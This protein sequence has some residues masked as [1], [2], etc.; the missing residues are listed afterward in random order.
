M[1]APAVAHEKLFLGRRCELTSTDWNTD[2]NR[3]LPRSFNGGI[4]RRLWKVFVHSEVLHLKVCGK[5]DNSP[6]SFKPLFFVLHGSA[7]GWWTS[8][9]GKVLAHGLR[10]DDQAPPRIHVYGF[11]LREAGG[12]AYL[13]PKCMFLPTI[14]CVL[15][16]KRV[17]LIYKSW[18]SPAR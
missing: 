12:Y 11:E 5:G 16:I 2:T 3:D 1:S 17:A 18:R 7:D 4:E 9:A 6:E 15:L 8:V 13:P 14:L 10:E